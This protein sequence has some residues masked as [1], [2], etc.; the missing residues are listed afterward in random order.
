M[1]SITCLIFNVL[2]ECL[3]VYGAQSTEDYIREEEQCLTFKM[4][5]VI[6]SA[7]QLK[8]TIGRTIGSRSVPRNS[9]SVV[10]VSEHYSW[11]R[12]FFL[13]IFPTD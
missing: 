8:L 13:N 7:V 12:F 11:W 2:C 1:I 3:K 5:R 9:N 6:Q 10:T 4:D